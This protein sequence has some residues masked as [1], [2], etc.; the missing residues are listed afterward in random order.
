MSV[1]IVNVIGLTGSVMS[2]YTD[3]ELVCFCSCNSIQLLS[4]ENY[5]SFEY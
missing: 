1:A 3:S 5:L 2:V 4:S